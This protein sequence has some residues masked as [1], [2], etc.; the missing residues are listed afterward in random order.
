MDGVNK[1]D[2]N[3]DMIG[4]KEWWAEERRVYGSGPSTSTGQSDGIKPPGGTSSPRVNKYDQYPD[5]IGSKEWWA[6]ERRVYGSGPS[7]S[8][9]Q[10]YFQKPTVIPS[11]DSNTSAKL[12]KLT[13]GQ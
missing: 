11:T 12:D 13:G 2:Q 1:Y 3:I 7:T 4:S 6:E 8:T 9:G 5:K 10:G